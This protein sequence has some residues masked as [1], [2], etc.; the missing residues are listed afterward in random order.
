MKLSTFIESLLNEMNTLHC[1]KSVRIPSYSGPH[2]PS[3]GLNTNQNNFE[4]GHFLRSQNENLSIFSLR[5]YLKSTK[6]N[7]KIQ[8]TMLFIR[9][10]SFHGNLT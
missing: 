8:T 7:S 9:M 6:H 3:F 4:Y 5:I 1:V 10:V 2:F